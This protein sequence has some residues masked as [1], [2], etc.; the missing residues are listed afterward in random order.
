[1]KY[2]SMTT[3]INVASHLTRMAD[4]QPDRP[5]VIV[6][7][8]QTHT[9][10]TFRQLHVES[11]ALA[12]G[13]ASIGIVRGLRTAVMVP[14]SLDF[15]TLT[16]ALFKLGAVP[17]LIDPGMG[18]RNLGRC[19]GEARPE[20]FIG[21][22]KAHLARKLLRWASDS[23][24]VTVTTSGPRWLLAQHSLMNW[25]DCPTPFPMPAFESDDPAAI[26]FTS[27]STGPAKGAVYTHGIFSKQVD[28]LRQI[29][30]IEPGEIDLATFPLFA[31]FGPALGMTAIIPDMDPT[32]PGSVDPLK[33]ASAI[34]D[35]GAT[36]MFGSPA[37]LKRVGEWGRRT[38]TT[39]PSLRRVISC[40]APVPAS[41]LDTFIGL[42]SPSVEV[43]TPYG[44]T[45]SLP[46]ANIGSDEILNE[47]RH[48]TEQG[49]GV[50]IGRPV[51][52]MRV[53]IIPISDSPIPVWDDELP[54]PVG[55]VGEIT[56]SGPVVT[57]EYFNRDEATALAKI[58]DPHTHTVWH[59]MGDLG[60]RDD[61]GRL[62]FYGRKAHRVITPDGERYTI[63][64]EAVFNTHDAV[65]RTA[66]VGVERDGTTIPVICVELRS[67]VKP[68]PW[69]MIETELRESTARFPH[70][71]GITHFLRHPAFPVDIRHNAKIFR[72]K[73]AVWAARKL[74]GRPHRPYTP[75]TQSAT[76]QSSRSEA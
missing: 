35:F 47:T 44:A 11:D 59:R 55:V 50:C 46:V 16:F 63:P 60:R 73:L 42:L 43:F 22:G 40:G 39:F 68:R 54:L 28:L 75:M 69:P 19:L 34:H 7:R 72:E 51:P 8:G 36:N 58:R 12:H 29:Y 45:E 64:C 65:I 1:M 18:I 61:Q 30:A 56:V 25:R 4:S 48:A 23:I 66:L 14:P 41:T 5:A 21:I 2:D 3:S 67:D 6:P 27:G 38:G 15:F 13:L 70:T 52:E 71:A 9:S 53:E 33:I 62:W 74:G 49:A 31:L 10:L 24:R 17:V 57:R 26:L 20:A 37:L 32:R 76:P